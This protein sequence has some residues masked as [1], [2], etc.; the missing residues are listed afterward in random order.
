MRST[1]SRVTPATCGATMK[2]GSVSS[3][4]FCGV[5]SWSKTSSA[6]A[7][8]VVRLQRVVERL[9]VDDAA[10]RGVDDEGGRLHMREPRGVEEAGRLGRF[11]AMDR[12]EVGP[13]Q[14]GVEVLRRLVSHAADHLRIHIRVVDQHV[15]LHRPR[16]ELAQALL[17][18]GHFRRGDN[19]LE[20]RAM[21]KRALALFEE[22]NATGWIAEA[23][24]ALEPPT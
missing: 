8:D 6:G 16:P 14:P 20:D 3:G 17:A 4:L 22:M 1:T 21:I 5:G 18:Y 23:R 11:R 24:A 12:D 9:F 15:G 7:G 13:R 19:A 10:A 2:F